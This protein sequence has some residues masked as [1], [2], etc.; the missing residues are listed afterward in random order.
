MKYYVRYNA[1]PKK[2]AELRLAVNVGS[3]AENDN[4]QGLAHFTEHMAFN[5]SKNFKKNELVD[6][7]E[8]VGTKFG[9]HLN[10][11]TSFDETV[12]MIQIPTDKEDILQKG[13]QIL[14]DW[15]HNLTFD[16]VEIDKERGVVTEE[17]RLGQGANERMRR[18][19][20]PV[21]FKDSRYAERLPIGKKDILQHC[22]Y[23]TLRSFYRDWYRPDLLAVMAVGDFD[24]D[25]IVALIKERFS[26]VPVKSSPR[27]LKSWPVPDHTSFDVSVAT[28]KEATYTSVQLLYMLP[29]EPATTEADYRKMIMR[30]LY[31]GMMNQRL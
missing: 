26:K 18:T 24:P 10:A 27:P 3:T 25:K 22:S 14:E 8:S 28:D 21:L 29:V 7:L 31:N 20:W 16:S 4:Q 13:F 6:Y 12:Y 19:Y 30:Q 5:G 2:R 9:P 1:R 11:Y 15:S 17:W 23:E